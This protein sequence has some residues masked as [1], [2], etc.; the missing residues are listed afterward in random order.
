MSDAPIR[1]FLMYPFEDAE[2]IVPI[3]DYL[4]DSGFDS[5]RMEHDI[6]P[7]E[8]WNDSIANALDRADVV[9]LFINRSSSDRESLRYEAELLNTR[10]IDKLMPVL[11]DDAA[12]PGPYQ[13]IQAF[14]FFDVA[15]EDF[16]EALLDLER[17]IRSFVDHRRSVEHPR[18]E[19]KTATP[20]DD[21][22]APDF[23]AESD[24]I[25]RLLDSRQYDLALERIQALESR[26]SVPAAIRR[27]KGR[28]L[29]ESGQLEKAVAEFQQLY[30]AGE[31]DPETI[32]HFA[33]ALTTQA[34]AASDSQL[35]S[36]ARDLYA[37]GFRSDPQ[38]YNFGIAAA[39]ESASLGEIEA[40]RDYAARV[41]E[42]S[43]ADAE[44]G[45]FFAV[46]TAA[47]AYLILGDIDHAASLYKSQLEADQRDPFFQVTAWDNAQRLMDVLGTE[48]EDRQQIARALAALD[49]DEATSEPVEPADVDSASA[50]RSTQESRGKT[51]SGESADGPQPDAKASRSRELTPLDLTLIGLGAALIFLGFYLDRSVP[52]LSDGVLYEDLA[53]EFVLV[54]PQDFLMGSQDEASM[55]DERPAH[56]VEFSYSILVGVHEVTNKLYGEFLAESGASFGPAPSFAATGSDL[57]PVVNV[58]FEDAE[59][60]AKWFSQRTGGAYRL[61][62]ESE[63]EWLAQQSA[64]LL[65]APCDF[66]NFDDIGQCPDSSPMLVNDEELAAD[67]LGLK[68]LFGNAAEWVK[69]CYAS[70]YLYA[71][72]DGTARDE[73]NCKYRVIRGGSWTSRASSL[74]PTYRA[75]ASPQYRDHHVGFRLVRDVDW[76]DEMALQSPDTD[77]NRNLAIASYLAWGTG[78]LLIAVVYWRLP[79]ARIRTRPAST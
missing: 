65:D 74:A 39:T 26:G 55:V 66:V 71:T 8:K 73:G 69:D 68:H 17:S 24:A 7:G 47:Q 53:A 79:R 36:Q 30:D 6:G 42:Q 22:K 62:S 20:G 35:R 76:L 72:G 45:N 29:M 75:F 25:T 40:A 11:L 27:L 23:T 9:L 41:V 33:Q 31:R 37:E 14:R 58:S 49:D 64:S 60:F 70:N 32:G 15:N 3:D 51:D 1:L 54:E 19:E 57:W 16:D 78:G 46:D 2:R 59:A 56:N 21:V 50:E 52:E 10:G 18:T 48:P 5:Y 34:D 13:E 67:T 44:Q 43:E 12:I 38:E 61:P 4:R 63:W 77:W 28:V